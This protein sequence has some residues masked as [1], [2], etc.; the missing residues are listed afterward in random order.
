MVDDKGETM[1]SLSEQDRS[2]L[3]SSS[4]SQ[5]RGSHLK[6]RPAKKSSG[7]RKS[8][9]NKCTTF[10]HLHQTALCFFIHVSHHDTSY[11]VV[12]ETHNHAFSTEKL[13][14]QNVSRD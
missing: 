4:D 1:N 8:A 11:A 9:S 6:C 3:S 10:S 13:R 2:I 7:F 12:Y 14:R 5:C